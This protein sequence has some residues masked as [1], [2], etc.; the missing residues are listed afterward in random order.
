MLLGA[1]IPPVLDLRENPY[2]WGMYQYKLGKH[3]PGVKFSGLKGTDE[4]DVAVDD[5][6]QGPCAQTMC[7]YH[8]QSFFA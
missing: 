8:S 7:F 2:G 5:V 4:L 6:F 3:R 1:H